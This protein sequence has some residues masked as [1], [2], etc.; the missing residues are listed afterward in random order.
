MVQ[1][2]EEGVLRGGGLLVLAC[3][4]FSA[5]AITE[6]EVV[7]V[8]GAFVVQ[9]LV[10]GGGVV[11]EQ[12]DEVEVD[13]LLAVAV[14]VGQAKEGVMQHLGGEPFAGGLIEAAADP[15]GPGE[16]SPAGEEGAH[17]AGA[18]VLVLCRRFGRESMAD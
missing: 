1:A 18:L 3:L 6:G 4:L 10:G 11:A 5:A 7:Q 14:V 12:T 13:D 17:W 9:L 16:A 15:F 8:G 2:S